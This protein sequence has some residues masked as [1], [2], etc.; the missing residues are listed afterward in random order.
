MRL[1]FGIDLARVVWN[2][3]LSRLTVTRRTPVRRGTRRPVQ[4]DPVAGD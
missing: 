4:S 1:S 2:W 3:L